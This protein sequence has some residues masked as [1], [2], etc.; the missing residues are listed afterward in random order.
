M[1]SCSVSL[2]LKA[3][4]KLVP[5]ITTVPYIKNLLGT[6]TTSNTRSDQKLLSV[7]S[8]DFYIASVSV[9]W[10]WS[11]HHVLTSGPGRLGLNSDQLAHAAVLSVSVSVSDSVLAWTSCTS[12]SSFEDTLLKHEL[13]TT[14]QLHVQ[15]I[16]A[17]CNFL[18]GFILC[19]SNTETQ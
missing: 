18:S 16:K 2:L 7:S 13:L 9:M 3:Q 17:H 1:S 14:A 11:P 12:L 10:P 19:N 5:K 6:I 4:F 8:T 15:A